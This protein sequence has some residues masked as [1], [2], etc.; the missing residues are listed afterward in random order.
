MKKEASELSSS[1]VDHLQG[2]SIV[3]LQATDPESLSIYST[4]LSWVYAVHPTS[5]YFAIDSKSA[6]LKILE[7]NPQVTLN[8]IACETAYAI[9]GKAKVKEKKAEG[10]SIHLALIE[11]EVEAVRDV[12]FFGGKVVTEPEFIK[13]YDQKLIDKLDHEVSQAV[14]RLAK[15]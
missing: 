1:L 3:F 8:T 14:T 9:N 12:M 6:F 7:Q 5:I 4:A 13:T 15:N 10:I 2:K 11:V